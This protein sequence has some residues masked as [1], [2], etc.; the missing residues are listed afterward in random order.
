VVLVIMDGWGLSPPNRGNAIALANTPTIDGISQEYP[1]ITLKA[2]GEAVGLPHGE[3]GNTETGHLNIGAGQI[4]YQDLL[5]INQ[6]I[7]SGEFQNNQEFL[8][9]IKHTK[10]HGS[11]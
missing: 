11:T 7:A 10:K 4:V 1:F 2:S 3:D 5:R 8:A 6:S 9:A